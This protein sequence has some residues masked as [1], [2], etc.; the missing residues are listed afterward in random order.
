MNLAQLE[1]DALIKGRTREAKNELINK[2]QR[3]DKINAAK[4]LN[5]HGL[6]NRLQIDE[7]MHN[8]L[9]PYLKE[10]YI[11]K[12]LVQECTPV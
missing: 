7:K 9:T 12:Q 3:F 1:K 2:M 5:K 11:N 4:A 10:Q 8:Q 6:L